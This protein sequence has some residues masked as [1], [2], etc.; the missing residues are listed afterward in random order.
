MEAIRLGE[1]WMMSLGR[2][3]K[4]DLKKMFDGVV[5]KS[6]RPRVLRDFMLPHTLHLQEQAAT[7]SD[8]YKE[9]QQSWFCGRSLAAGQ[10]TKSA[11]RAPISKFPEVCL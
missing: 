11:K 10:D 1:G 7:T 9:F 8:W 4:A 5:T 2:L 6:R 3:A